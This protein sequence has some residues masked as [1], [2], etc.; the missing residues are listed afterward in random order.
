MYH[1]LSVT[2]WR[3]EV[4]PEEMVMLLISSWI[5]L[6]IFLFILS[7]Q[8]EKLFWYLLIRYSLVMSK[9]TKSIS[10]WSMARCL[11]VA[12]LATFVESTSQSTF[13]YIL[14]SLCSI[15]RSRQFFMLFFII[16]RIYTLPMIWSMSFGHSTITGNSWY[17]LVYENLSGLMENIY[18]EAMGLIYHYHTWLDIE[19]FSI[20][21]F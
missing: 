8:S 19:L 16:I 10:M 6:H 5:L 14:H 15:R 12:F 4:W 9:S 18:A 20:H 13:R 2:I 3:L 17:D 11:I 21:L 1:S 7:V